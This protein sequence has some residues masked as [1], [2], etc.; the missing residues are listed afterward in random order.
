M[1]GTI[2][3]VYE[4]SSGRLFMHSDLPDTMSKEE[5]AELVENP[6]GH[7]ARFSASIAAAIRQLALVR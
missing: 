7:E 6:S 3:Q 5:E 4:D 2:L 1:K